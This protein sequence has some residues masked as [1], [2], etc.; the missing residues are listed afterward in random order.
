MLLVSSPHAINDEWR[1]RL[2]K[3]SCPHQRFLG[4]YE[5]VMKIHNLDSY[6][7]KRSCAFM[8]SISTVT[9]LIRA[10]PYNGSVNSPTYTGGRQYGGVFYVVRAATVEFYC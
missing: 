10:L 8:S 9:D 2:M 5:N 1:I 6:S 4:K 3:S 7:S